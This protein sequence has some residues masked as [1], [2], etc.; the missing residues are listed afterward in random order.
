MSFDEEGADWV[1]EPKRAIKKAN[2]TFTTM[3]LWLIVRHC[4]SPTAADNIVTWV[5][6][7]LMVAMIA[8][9]EVDFAWLLQEFMHERAFKV[10]T[11]YPFPFMIFS[12]CRSAG[13][14]IWHVDQLKTPLGIVD[15]GLIR[16]EGN[17]LAPRRGP[18]PEMPPLGDILADTVAQARTATQAASTD[19]TPVESIPGSS[20]APSSSRSAPLPALV[21]LARVQ[22]LEAQIATL[23]HHIQP[24]MQRSITEAEERLERKMVQHTERKIAE[25]HQCL[26]AFE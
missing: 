9:F 20:T 24:W 15:V 5:R 23:L 17:E 16:D 25:V 8:G 3:F 4:L 1:T 26:D 2:L 10:T 7:V 18:R 11:T 21:P 22:K 19:T 12:L 14:P 6:A 13:V